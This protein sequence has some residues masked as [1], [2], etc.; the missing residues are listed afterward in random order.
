MALPLQ[1]IKQLRHRPNHAARRPLQVRLSRADF[2][3][4]CKSFSKIEFAPQDIT[5]FGGLELIRR[6]FRLI[7]LHRRVQSV[8]ARYGIGGDYR[9]IDMILVIVML[10][11]V[12]GRRLDHLNYLL[13]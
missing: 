6:Y 2:H 13:W 1:E 9:A 7:D 4:V 3:S 5:A 10:M 8:F 12:G 11:L